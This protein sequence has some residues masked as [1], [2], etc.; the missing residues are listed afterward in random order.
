MSYVTQQEKARHGEATTTKVRQ[1]TESVNDTFWHN[2]TT[3][4]PV[5]RVT[6]RL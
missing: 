5:A 1:L 4:A 6:D 3:G 2:N